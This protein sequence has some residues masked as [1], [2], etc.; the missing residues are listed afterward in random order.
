MID[1]RRPEG[2]GHHHDD[3]TAVVDGRSDA[4]ARRGD[5]SRRPIDRDDALAKWDARHD[6]FG[7]AGRER[8]TARPRESR[9]KSLR[10]AGFG[11]QFNEHEWVAPEHGR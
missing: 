3:R 4:R 11:V 2:A 9:E 8:T 5:R 6:G 7:I 1:L 10:R